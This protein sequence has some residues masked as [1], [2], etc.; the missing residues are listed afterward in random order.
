MLASSARVRKQPVFSPHHIEPRYIPEERKFGVCSTKSI[1][2]QSRGNLYEEDGL[3]ILPNM[4]SIK[5][6]YLERRNTIISQYAT[7]DNV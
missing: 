6:K 5:L 4:M 2:V 7:A 3:R 1:N